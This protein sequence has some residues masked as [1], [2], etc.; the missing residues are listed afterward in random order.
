M[1][2]RFEGLVGLAAAFLAAWCAVAAVLPAWQLA[3]GGV[4]VPGMVVGFPVMF[5]LAS[6]VYRNC[7]S[8]A[9]RN[10]QT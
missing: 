7:R 9:K 1:S 8:A 5:W 4:T 2:E 6:R 3:V 10:C